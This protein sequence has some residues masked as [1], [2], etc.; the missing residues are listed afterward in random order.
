MVKFQM[1][2]FFLLLAFVTSGQREC[3]YS[4]LY[5]E[6]QSNLSA[7]DSNTVRIFMDKNGYYYPDIIIPDQELKRACNSIPNF[8]ITNWVANNNL[9]QAFPQV[10]FENP[11][12]AANV[13]NDIIVQQHI[14]RINRRAAAY[15]SVTFLIHGYRKKAWGNI[16]SYNSLSYDDF[17]AVKNALQ[18]LNTLFI[19]IYWDSRYI[20]PKKFLKQG[21]K[22]PLRL[23]ENFVIPNSLQVGLSLRNLVTG[24]Q[25]T[26]LNIFTHSIGGLVAS[27]MLF[28]ASGRNIPGEQTLR[29]PVIPNIFLCM[30]APA[31]A[32][33]TLTNNYYS[34]NTSYDFNK[35]DNYRLAIVFNHD[36]IALTK[37]FGGF[38]RLFTG[39]TNAL[40]YGN[41]SLGCDYMNCLASVQ[42]FFQSHNNTVFY[43]P[44]DVTTYAGGNHYMA[45]YVSAPTF[46]PTIYPLC[47]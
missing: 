8:I 28:N 31:M 2:T 24:L 25:V 43:P 6:N 33:E 30:V 32:P 40:T 39:R 21:A 1:L 14:E 45:S 10:S 42:G 23:F 9:R 7:P 15:N 44:L 37:S 12:Q 38:V 46:R 26:N 13:I 19:E 5:G 11:A 17:T 22:V 4:V 35:A 3:Q 47:R 36:D 34:R 41:T 20:N 27:E 16:D 18:G 29:T